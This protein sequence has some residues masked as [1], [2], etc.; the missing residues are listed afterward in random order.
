[1]HVFREEMC[2]QEGIMTKLLFTSI[3]VAVLCLVLGGC[4]NTGD[5]ST[6][7]NPQASRAKMSDA[8]LEN[9]V[10]A[11]LDTDSQLKAAGIDVDADADDNKV[12]LSGTVESEALRMKAVEMAKS[13]QPGVVITD[14]IDVKPREATRATYTEDQARQEREKGKSAGDKIGDTLDDAWIHTKIVTKLITDSNTPERKINVDVLNGAVTLR[15]T[16]DNNEQKMEAERLAK[17]TEGVKQVINQ[18]KVGGAM[19]AGKK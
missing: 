11:R 6:G 5:T 3:L 1:M 4:H 18:L 10:K 7:A 8:D 14:R 17:N 12:T 15:G 19:P 16:V 13:A 2:S 9:N